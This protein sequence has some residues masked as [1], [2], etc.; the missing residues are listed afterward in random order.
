MLEVLDDN[1]PAG[2]VEN[3]AAWLPPRYYQVILVS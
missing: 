2:G 3:P 1:E